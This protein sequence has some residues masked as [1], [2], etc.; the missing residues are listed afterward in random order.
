[1]LKRKG[2]K[3]FLGNLRKGNIKYTDWEGRNKA[4]C[5]QM[6]CLFMEKIPKNQ[7]KFLKLS[8]YGKVAKLQGCMFVS[9]QIQLLIC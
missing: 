9:M 5:S 3:V 7:Q 1:M 4:L 8:D 2:R 6:T